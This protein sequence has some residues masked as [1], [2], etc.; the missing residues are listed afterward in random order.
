M[1]SFLSLFNLGSPFPI[2]SAKAEWYV[3]GQAWERNV[4]S[5]L[6]LSIYQEVSRLDFSF[7]KLPFLQEIPKRFK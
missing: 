3:E 7:I 4:F 2:Q 1:A 6:F 5:F